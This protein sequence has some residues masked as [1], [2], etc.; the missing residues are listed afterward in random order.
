MRR[1]SLAFW[2]FSSCLL[3]VLSLVWVFPSSLRGQFPSLRSNSLLAQ[4]PAETEP[5][6]YTC[7]AGQSLPAATGGQ[8]VRCSTSEKHW[9]ST[10]NLFND[11]HKI[12]IGTTTPV[13]TLDVLGEIKLGN[14][15]PGTKCN[16]QTAGALR[17][18]SN[19]TSGREDDIYICAKQTVQDDELL[20]FSWAKLEAVPQALLSNLRTDMVKNPQYPYLASIRMVFAL[21][22]TTQTLYL[23]KTPSLLVATSSTADGGLTAI[24]TDPCWTCCGIY[25]GVPHCENVSRFVIEKGTTRYFVLTGP[26]INNTGFPTVHAFQVNK[27][28]YGNDPHS[29]QELAIEQGLDNLHG[30]AFLLNR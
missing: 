2:L 20:Q 10:E 7:R 30:A 29:L 28:Y 4:V 1:F 24:T 19:V 23:S 14:T 16:S 13:V 8:T 12:G 5:F 27:L 11:G 6:Y 25:M 17:F 22:A 9:V 3:F 15:G 21:T 18:V 26:I